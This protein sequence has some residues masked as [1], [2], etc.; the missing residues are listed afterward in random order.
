MRR[1]S[2]PCAWIDARFLDEL[3]WYIGGTV[4]ASA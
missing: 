1:Q 4:S 2:S 3:T